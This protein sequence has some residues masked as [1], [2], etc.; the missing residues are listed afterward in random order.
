MKYLS[1][2]SL[3]ALAACSAGGSAPENPNSVP[4]IQRSITQTRSSDAYIYI[5]G[6]V[7]DGA[8]VGQTGQFV[9]TPDD[10]VICTFRMEPVL[11]QD[12]DLTTV[13]GHRIVVPGA[14]VALT[15]IVTPN[16]LPANSE[17]LSNFTIE[18]GTRLGN[19]TSV[20]GPDDPRY[21]ELIRYFG[22]NSTPCWGFG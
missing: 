19:S 17:V 3:L 14:F 10:S 9:V 5:T 6:G 20:T 21:L 15:D 1:L 12:G 7:N 11:P 18:V 8:A 2:I 22:M 4:N 13:T 16:V